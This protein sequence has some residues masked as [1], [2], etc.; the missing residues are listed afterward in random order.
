[1]PRSVVRVSASCIASTAAGARGAVHDDLG[2]QRV[3]ERRDLG[4]GRTHVSTRTSFGP[5]VSGH[6]ASVTRPGL[7]TKSR[8]GSSAY[9]RASI[10]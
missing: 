9:T 5:E 3:V 7:G 6:D 1:M 4:A 2:E 8:A 10:A